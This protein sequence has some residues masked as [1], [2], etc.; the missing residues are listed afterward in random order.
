[1]A[2][3]F[4]AQNTSYK[5]FP[6]NP[7]VGNFDIWARP[8]S[9]GKLGTAV[10]ISQSQEND[11]WPVAT[12]DSAGKVWIAWQGAR[13][14]TFRILARHQDDN[15]WPPEQPATPQPPTCWPP[16]IPASP[17]GNVAVAWD[18]YEKGDYDIWVRE[19]EK[20]GKPGEARP[21]A[22]TFDYE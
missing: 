11:I 2:W 15:G 4:W 17:G 3:I 12:T 1:T 13:N 14:K 22:N 9:G 5:P 16:T 7:K 8:L 10:Q 21:A 18:P 6:N 20:A 19:F